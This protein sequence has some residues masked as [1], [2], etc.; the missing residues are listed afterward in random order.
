MAPLFPL[1]TFPT[2]ASLCLCM[3]YRFVYGLLRRLCLHR[4]LYRLQKLRRHT[5]SPSF[6]SCGTG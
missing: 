1:P 4:R 2:Y 6:L 3:A 5:P